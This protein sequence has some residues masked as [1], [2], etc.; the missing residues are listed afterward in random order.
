MINGHKWHEF[1][2]AIGLTIAV[3]FLLYHFF[4]QVPR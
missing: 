1:A 3:F 2:L 4:P